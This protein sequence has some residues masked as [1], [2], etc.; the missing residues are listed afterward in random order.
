MYADPLTVNPLDLLLIF[1]GWSVKQVMDFVEIIDVDA[2]GKIT[3]A[4]FFIGT[5]SPIELV[6]FFLDLSPI[7]G[8]ITEDQLE[9]GGI[10]PSSLTEDFFDSFNQNEDGGISYTEWLQ[11]TQLSELMLE[12]FESVDQL[13]IWEF[14][15]LFGSQTTSQQLSEKF[16]DLDADMNQILDWPEFIKVAQ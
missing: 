4:E 10:I 12:Y 1:E 11:A 15:L 14:S 8:K 2:D 16:N 5:S 3:V 6:D 7:D 13:G 9:L